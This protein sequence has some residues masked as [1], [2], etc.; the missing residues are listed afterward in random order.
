MKKILT[1]LTLLLTFICL[2]VDAEECTYA[3]K[4]QLNTAASHIKVEY[5]EKTGHYEDGGCD[6]DTCDD[7]Y[8]YFQVSILNLTDDMYAVVSNNYNKDVI[9]LYASDADKNG[10]VK[11]DWLYVMKKVTFTIKIYGSNDTNCY[12]TLIKTYTKALPRLNEHYFDD[13][14][15]EIPDSDICQKYVFYDEIDYAKFYRIAQ[16]EI[17]QKKAKQKEKEE[18]EK[19]FLEKVDDFIDKYKYYFIGGGVVVIGVGAIIVIKRKKDQE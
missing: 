5:E 7:A 11:F 14:C 8:N 16:D 2:T 17:E 6:G 12:G 15:R 18:K 19:T 3:E 9:Y 4:Q 13:T 10:V 1:F